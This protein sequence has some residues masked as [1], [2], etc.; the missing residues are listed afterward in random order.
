MVVTALALKSDSL[1]L[2]SGI[3][4]HGCPHYSTGTRFLKK[5]DDPDICGI[6]RGSELGLEIPGEAL[7]L[8]QLAN[9]CE[10][11]EHGDVLQVPAAIF[12]V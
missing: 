2:L 9:F 3:F 10:G 8:L 6:Q 7:T 12:S 4:L 11:F 5:D 1:Q